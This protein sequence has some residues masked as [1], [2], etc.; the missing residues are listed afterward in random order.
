M[1]ESGGLE[2][3][4][5][6]N[7]ST[8]GSN[9]SPS[10]I[11][12]DWRYPQR[13]CCPGPGALTPAV[14]LDLRVP[15]PS[16][17]TARRPRDEPGARRFHA[18]PRVRARRRGQPVPSVRGRRRHRQSRHWP[19]VAQ[20][21]ATYPR[22]LSVQSTLGGT[23]GSGRDMLAAGDGDDRLS[24]NSSRDR[25]F[26]ERGK[27]VLF[28][29]TGPDTRRRQRQRPHLLGRQMARQSPLRNRLRS[30]DRRSPGLSRAVSE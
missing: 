13:L 28:G 26:G 9:P 15:A 18:A 8:E 17:R 19:L 22:R 3:R 11:E 23:G 24:G 25:L 10:A 21:S 7:P 14:L 30:C 27:D 20:A 5:R 16:L 6:R 2:N 1:V 29:G 12:P 4:C